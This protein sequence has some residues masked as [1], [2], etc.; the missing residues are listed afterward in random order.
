VDGHSPRR[1][2]L[3]LLSSKARQLGHKDT[4]MV[5]KVYCMGWQ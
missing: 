5:A 2:A 1:R 4:A 3:A